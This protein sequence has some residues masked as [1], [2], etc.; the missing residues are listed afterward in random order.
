MYVFLFVWGSLLLR[1]VVVGSIRLVG[2]IEVGD[3]MW[4]LV[5]K[6]GFISLCILV[7]M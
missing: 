1:R 3:G 5:G 4:V 2:L 7:G 6:M